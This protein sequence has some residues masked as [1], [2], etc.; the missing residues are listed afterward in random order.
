M[1]VKWYLFKTIIQVRKYCS[2][3]GNGRSSIMRNFMVSPIESGRWR[4]KNQDRKFMSLE[5]GVMW[6][7]SKF[8]NLL[9][10]DKY[11]YLAIDERTFIIWL[12]KKSRILIMTYW[13]Y[14]SN[15][16]YA[17]IKEKR[18]AI[19]CISKI[20]SFFFYAMMIKYTFNYN[21]YNS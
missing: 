20:G 16:V 9:K 10:R 13:M 15:S 4:I 17:P 19:I 18:L 2:I 6:M 11:E 1:D 7:P 8:K 3:Q 14:L 21:S 5:S 12:S